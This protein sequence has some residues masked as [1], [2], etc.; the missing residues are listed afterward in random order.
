ME[1]NK[2][3]SDWSVSKPL[4]VLV[5]GGQDPLGGGQCLPL[6]GLCGKLT[7]AGSGSQGL[8]VFPSQHHPLFAWIS[9]SG[10]TDSGPCGLVLRFRTGWAV[11]R[12]GGEVKKTGR[13][14][15]PPCPSLGQ[16]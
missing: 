10:P 1:R 13:P 14:H 11:G 12:W 16:F 7:P 6:S 15:K 8:T 5:I 2:C 4:L 3:L 9:S